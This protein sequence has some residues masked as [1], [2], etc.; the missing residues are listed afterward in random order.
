MDRAVHG[1]TL[2]LRKGR[3]L[4]LGRSFSNGGF[5]QPISFPGWSGAQHDD[6]REL[7]PVPSGRSRPLVHARDATSSTELGSS[8]DFFVRNPGPE[9]TAGSAA[10]GAMPEVH[11]IDEECERSPLLLAARDNDF[12]G[13]AA[14]LDAGADVN[15]SDPVTRA[16]ALMRASERWNVEAVSLLL[17][18]KGIDID[19]TNL[20]GENALMAAIS[21]VCTPVVSLLLQADASTAIFSDDDYGAGHFKLV[22]G[23]PSLTEV[24]LEHG[25]PLDPGEV[26]FLSPDE[27]DLAAAVADLCA[28]HE[29]SALHA[30]APGAVQT[31]PEML[32]SNLGCSEMEQAI[33]K[34][35]RGGGM[36]AAPAL[37]VLAVLKQAEACRMAQSG[38]AAQAKNLYLSALSW[39]R[40]LGIDRMALE[41]YRAGGI[42][43]PGVKRLGAVTMDQLDE[44]AALATEHLATVGADMLDGLED[45]CAASTSPDGVVAASVLSASLCDSGFCAPVA[46]AIALGWQ[47]AVAAVREAPIVSTDGVALEPSTAAWQRHVVLQAQAI[48]SRELLRQLGARDRLAELRAEADGGGGGVLHAQFQIQCDWLRQY[49]NQQLPDLAASTSSTS[50]TLQQ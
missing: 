3:R 9:N 8:T 18:Q 28:A 19:R 1:K 20:L 22:V 4:T 36:R 13:L 44:L 21:Y 12:L 32:S 42:S 25:V 45:D 50:S 26:D 30:F 39:L 2:I 34:W 5:M 33:F 35:L 24:F 48:F 46:N 17:A 15:Y 29:T 40:A 11:F 43:E 31:L 10:S 16:T 38:S 23:I 37:Q 7:Q 6:E 27:S 14:L 49:C 47:C 41:Y